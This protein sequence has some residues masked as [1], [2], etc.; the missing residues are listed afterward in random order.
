MQINKTQQEKLKSLHKS[1]AIDLL[2]LIAD[3]QIE[4]LRISRVPLSSDSE[5]L[6]NLH[7]SFGGEKYLR[8]Y[9]NYLYDCCNSER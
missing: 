2:K 5:T 1:G 4:D 7:E 6:R 8:N 9:F 3:Q